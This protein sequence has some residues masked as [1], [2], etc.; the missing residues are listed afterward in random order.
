[1][2]SVQSVGR[3]VGRSVALFTDNLLNTPFVGSSWECERREQR[4]PIDCDIIWRFS[5]FVERR[6]YSH[7]SSVSVFAALQVVEERY[8][9]R[10]P[11]ITSF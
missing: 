2:Y 1:M 5:P 4:K 9:A 11:R 6:L 7:C 10:W 3:S 8:S